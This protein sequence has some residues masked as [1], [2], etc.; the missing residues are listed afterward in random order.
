MSYFLPC[1]KVPAARMPSVVCCIVGYPTKV[2]T[3][4]ACVGVIGDFL[5]AQT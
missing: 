5:D 1:V 3:S 4:G 2:D